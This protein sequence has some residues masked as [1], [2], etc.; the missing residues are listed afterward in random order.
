MSQ[1]KMR[2]KIKRLEDTIDEMINK[3]E[4]EQYVSLNDLN[5]LLIK[6]NLKTYEIDS[7]IE[8]CI[9]YACEDFDKIYV[10]IIDKN[11]QYA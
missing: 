6:N 5:K 1:N 10:D 4:E 8:K 11:R 2:R 9:E 3:I 7:E